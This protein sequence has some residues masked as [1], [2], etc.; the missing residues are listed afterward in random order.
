MLDHV[1]VQPSAIAK[2][3]VQLRENALYGNSTNVKRCSQTLK[4]LDEFIQTHLRQELCVLHSTITHW[5][6]DSRLS[7]SDKKQFLSALKSAGEVLLE[8]V[9]LVLG[10]I[11]DRMRKMAL[12]S[13]DDDDQAISEILRMFSDEFIK[14]VATGKFDAM[15]IEKAV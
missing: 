7:W 6:G 15:H 1:V 4:I 14:V 13:N 2:V 12:K 10:H 9:S 5:E 8:D 3:A 11:K